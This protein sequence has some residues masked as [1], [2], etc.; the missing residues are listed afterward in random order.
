MAV[1]L[2]KDDGE[3]MN[4]E[5]HQIQSHLADGWRLTKDPVAATKRRRKSV[6]KPAPKA[7]V[8]V[9]KIIEDQPKADY[10]NM[11]LRQL[12]FLTSRAG[13]SHDGL[14]KEELVDLLTGID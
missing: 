14:S 11:N 12:R 9:V 13:R 5:P 3:I 6:K 1:I 10:D 2:Y 8:P 7:V 4:C